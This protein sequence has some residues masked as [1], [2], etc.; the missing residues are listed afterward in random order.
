VDIFCPCAQPYSITSDN[1]S[2]VVAKIISPGA[3]VPVTPEAEQ[4]LFRRGI[5]SIP[6]FVANCG[7]A[8]GVTMEVASLRKDFIIRFIDHRFRQTVTEIIEAAQKENIICWVYAERIA[9]ERFLGAKEAAEKRTITAKS[10]NL[11]LELYRK[12]IIPSRI[13]TPIT[14]RYFE[15]S[16]RKIPP[17]HMVK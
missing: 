3:N 12:G 8:L 6:D 5:L 1:A 2:R 10:F 17:G 13:V 11:A 7:G 4:I 9:E 15:R 16:F 14:S